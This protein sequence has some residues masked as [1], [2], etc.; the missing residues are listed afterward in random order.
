MNPCSSN[1]DCDS[2]SVSRVLSRFA[3]WLGVEVNASM[4]SCSGDGGM[5]SSSSDE[6]S[7]SNS[8]GDWAGGELCR[9]GERV[10]V[11]RATSSS[12]SSSSSE[13]SSSTEIRAGGE[14]A[15]RRGFATAAAV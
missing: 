1:I 10:N 7:S 6:R 9:E 11:R 15:R 13:D 14:G 2:V 8:G 3:G 4:V 12:S 5:E